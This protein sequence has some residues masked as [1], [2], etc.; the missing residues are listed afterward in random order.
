MFNAFEL[1]GQSSLLG[2]DSSLEKEMEIC[3]T[4]F[5]TVC[6]HGFVGCGH[7]VLL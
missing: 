6:L 5:T 7:L 4:T 3:N 2:G 1:D